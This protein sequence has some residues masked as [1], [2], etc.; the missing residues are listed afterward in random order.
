MPQDA[1]FYMREGERIGPVTFAGLQEIVQEGGL[2]PRLDMVWTQ[3]MAEWQTAGT[4]DGLFETRSVPEPPEDLAPE[5]DPYTPPQ[6]EAMTDPMNREGEWPGARRRGFLAAT[7]L[8]PVVWNIGFSLGAAAL[9]QQFGT[10]IMA[11]L[12]V[13]AVL[14]PMVV[15]IIYG[16]KRLV[17]LGMSRWWYLVNFVPILNLWVGYRCFACPAGYAFHKK[18]DGVGVALAIIYWL[19]MLIC[20]V[21]IVVTVALLLGAIDS[22]ELQQQIQEILRAARDQA[23]KP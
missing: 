3:G 7:L 21:A 17:N 4:I 16:L 11:Y 18:L 15:S 2:N 20:V 1:W 19:I 5:A 10:E 23:A 14:V 6:Q 8:F 22:P 12:G 13:V 9:A